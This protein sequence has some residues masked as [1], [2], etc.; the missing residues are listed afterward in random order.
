[1]KCARHPFAP[2]SWHTHRLWSRLIFLDE[3][4]S[5]FN[6][7]TSI[8]V[9]FG[10]S[11]SCDSMDC[12]FECNPDSNELNLSS[13]PHGKVRNVGELIYLALHSNPLA[14]T[15]GYLLWSDPP[16]KTVNME[17]WLNNIK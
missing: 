9:N 2:E 11:M 3:H 4:V 8:Y 5:T 14:H 16:T 10:G 12:P 15:T 6:T 7:K 1:M 17:R 13:R